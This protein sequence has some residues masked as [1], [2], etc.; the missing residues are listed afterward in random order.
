[1]GKFITVNAICQ[2]SFADQFDIQDGKLPTVTAFSPSKQRYAN[3][4]TPL[5]DTVVV[6]DFLISI[7]TGKLA[8]QPISDRPRFLDV[9]DVPEGIIETESSEEAADFLEEIRREEEAKAKQLKEELEE[10]RKTEKSKK[11]KKRKKKKSSK[12]K[13]L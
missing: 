9:C 12:D 4:K 8:T 2:S 3:V 13:D 11:K 5:V 10:E 1:M 6:K 7:A